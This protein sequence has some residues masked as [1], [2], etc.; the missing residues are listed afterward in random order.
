MKIKPYF[1]IKYYMINKILYENDKENLEIIYNNLKNKLNSFCFE[2]NQINIH[3]KNL[4]AQLE[5]YNNQTSQSFYALNH[6]ISINLPN[7]IA[8]YDQIYNNSL[9]MKLQ[10]E[11]NLKLSDSQL[12]NMINLVSNG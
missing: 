5:F 6:F 4:I 12:I 3:K 2:I 11:M 10:T 1:H 7:E 9:N 8:Y